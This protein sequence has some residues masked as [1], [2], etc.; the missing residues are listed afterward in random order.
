[1]RNAGDDQTFHT[2]IPIQLHF[3]EPFGLPRCTRLG[4]FGRRGQIDPRRN[5]PS[6]AW[7]SS[8]EEFPLVPSIWPARRVSSTP[9]E[10]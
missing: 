6:R 9:F 8:A 7:R 2:E 5:V 1:M 4:V 10:L 3:S